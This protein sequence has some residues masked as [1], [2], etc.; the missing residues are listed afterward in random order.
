MYIE[1][2]V[3][4]SFCRNYE[5]VGEYGSC[6]FYSLWSSRRKPDMSKPHIGVA[7]CDSERSSVATLASEVAAAITVLKYRYR[8]GDFVNFHTMP[9]SYAFILTRVFL[10]PLV[11]AE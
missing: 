9:V 10:F 6:G 3:T 2:D 4:H 11:G 5:L 7:V 1:E 8:R